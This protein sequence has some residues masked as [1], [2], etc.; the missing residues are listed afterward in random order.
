[1]TRRELAA[2]AVAPFVAAANTVDQFLSAVNSLAQAITKKQAGRLLVV[3]CGDW[4]EWFRLCGET[5]LLL[6]G[7]QRYEDG[8]FPPNG[9]RERFAETG[10]G[11]SKES[12]RRFY[13]GFLTFYGDDGAVKAVAATRDQLDQRLAAAPAKKSGALAF[14]RFNK[15]GP[16]LPGVTIIPMSEATLISA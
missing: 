10:H 8:Y 15:S 6:W 4:D 7:F 13:D 14:P 2:F 16:P 12:A 11:I 1:M 5:S 3:V 9:G